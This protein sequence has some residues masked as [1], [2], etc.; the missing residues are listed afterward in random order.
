M[1]SNFRKR[2]L[3]AALLAVTLLAAMTACVTSGPNEGDT[4]EITQGETE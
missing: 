4:S 2:F 1:K 3:A